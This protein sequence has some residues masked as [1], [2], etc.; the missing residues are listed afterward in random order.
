MIEVFLEQEAE[1]VE[2]EGERAEREDGNTQCGETGDEG[3]EE[4]TT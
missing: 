4:T 2:K 3:E 1:D